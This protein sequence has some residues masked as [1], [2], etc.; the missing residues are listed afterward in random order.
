MPFRTR[1]RVAPPLT[2][3]S[4]LRGLL[5]I[6]IALLAL[7]SCSTSPSAAKHAAASAPALPVANPD[8]APADAMK[9]WNGQIAFGRLDPGLGNFTLWSA[10]ADGS[11][12]R[13]LTT[14]PTFFSDWAPDGS[15]LVFDYPDGADE[16]IAAIA[17]N[18]SHRTRLTHGPGIQEVPRYSPDGRQIVFDASE[19]RPDDPAFTTAIW[20]MN[21]DGSHA[22][23]VTHGG[24]D[25]EPA[26]SPDGLRI[27]FGRIVG[28]TSQS[29]TAQSEAVYV[30]RSDGTG[31]H[32]VVEPRTALEHPRWS[33]DGRLLTFNIGP[34]DLS[35][36][37]AGTVFSVH[38]DGEGLRA[39][40]AANDAWKFTK[41]VWSPGGRAMLVVCHS[42]AANLDYLC[43]LNPRSGAFRVVV[44]TP[45]GQPVNFPSWG[46]ER[47]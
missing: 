25:V 44:R 2:R 3:R 20:V 27:V 23:Q 37:D 41:A 4:G 39:I 47:R 43:D 42:T 6:P 9:L 38:L 36:P 29:A 21:S 18:G 35:V 15:G 11:H 17:S 26:F 13:R 12:Q 8:A 31:L 34:E 10:R 28:A 45:Q 16:H 30:V 5:L 33:P 1:A 7:S 40:R 32:R 46:P 24:F 14:T 19:R 22:R